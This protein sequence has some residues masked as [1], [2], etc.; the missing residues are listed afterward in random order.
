[1]G[2]GA[3]NIKYYK[4]SCSVIPYVSSHDI[5]GANKLPSLFDYFKALRHVKEDTGIK[6]VSREVMLFEMY[7]NFT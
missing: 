5:A 6:V 2:Y 4:K 7:V 3:L 1:M